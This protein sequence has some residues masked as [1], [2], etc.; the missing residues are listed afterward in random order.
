MSRSIWGLV[1]VLSTSFLASL[2]VFTSMASASPTCTDTWA[3]GNG[4]WDTGSWSA[5]TPGVGS[6][7][8]I[9]SGTVTIS[10]TDSIPSSLASVSI[11]SDG[12]LDVGI[13]NVVTS[14]NTTIAAGG[15]LT[16]DGTYHGANAGDALRDDRQSGHVER[17]R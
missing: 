5:G 10:G 4:D 12:G 15:T 11:G 8:C 16:L 2:G 17:A 13:H 6:A 3:G 14:A 9:N 1:A 7:V